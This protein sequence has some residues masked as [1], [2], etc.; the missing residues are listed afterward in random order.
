MKTRAW[1]FE[2]CGFL[3]RCDVCQRNNRV[4]SK[5]AVHY[6]KWVFVLLDVKKTNV[7]ELTVNTIVNIAMKN[8]MRKEVALNVG[9]VEPCDGTW[10]LSFWPAVLV[11]VSVHVSSKWA[12]LMNSAH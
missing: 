9:R 7:L 11:E 6:H 12:P 3:L 8:R 1:N 5:G 10:F 4:P 2:C